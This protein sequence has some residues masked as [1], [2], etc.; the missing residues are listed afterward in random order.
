MRYLL[1]LTLFL[2][3]ALQGG[4]LLV[5]SGHTPYVSH[6]QGIAA[7]EEH[8]YWSFTR[9]LV[10]SDYTGKVKTETPLI[11]H[12]GDICIAEGDIYVATDHRPKEKHPTQSA[13]YRYGKDLKL[14]KVYPIYP[15]EIKIEGITFYKGKFY[16]GVGGNQAPHRKND[17]LVCD[18]EMKL[19]KRISVDIGRDT[20]FGVQ[21]LFVVNDRIGGGFYTTGDG[22]LLDPETLEVTG[23]FPLKPTEGIAQLPPG[24]A[25]HDSTWLLAHSLGKRGSYNGR[26]RIYKIVDGKRRPAPIATLKLPK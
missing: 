23:S 17:I 13:V 21:N 3:G 8:I 9:V 5:T 10:K 16:I 11:F 12:S 15:A 6:L 25:G 18:R 1:L 4:N 14:K 19:L 24:L 7:D 20:K 2:S 22:V 26:I